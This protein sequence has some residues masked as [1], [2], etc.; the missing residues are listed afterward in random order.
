LPLVIGTP[1]TAWKVLAAG[2]G[3]ENDPLL[4]LIE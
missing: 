3:V 1:S 2:Y 4:E